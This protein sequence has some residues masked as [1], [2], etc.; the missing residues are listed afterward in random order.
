LE[1]N[2]SS[3]LGEVDAAVAA[4]EAD[5]G[6]AEGAVCEVALALDGTD[7]CAA[8]ESDTDAECDAECAAECAADAAACNADAASS[9]AAVYAPLEIEQL[10][11][12][13]CRSDLSKK[14][15]TKEEVISH[16]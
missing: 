13:I 16:R 2:S 4:A 9:S 6:T 3:S 14:N 12:C 7:G 5:G 8:Q 15:Q 1:S 10:R 11:L